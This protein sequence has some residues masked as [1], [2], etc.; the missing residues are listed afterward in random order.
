MLGPF[1]RQTPPADR[2]TLRLPQFF[3]AALTGIAP[4]TLVCGRAARDRHSPLGFSNPFAR[5]AGFSFRK[6]PVL[7]RPQKAKELT[8]FS[9]VFRPFHVSNHRAAFPIEEVTEAELRILPDC[10]GIEPLQIR[11]DLEVDPQLFMPTQ[12]VFKVR[13][14]DRVVIGLRHMPV[15]RKSG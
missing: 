5:F 15:E 4:G 8:E 13:Y 2:G 14:Q 3:R 6:R 12:S 11:G 9:H 10:A 7:P 1:S